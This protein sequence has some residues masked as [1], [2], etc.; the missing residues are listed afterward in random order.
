MGDSTYQFMTR[1]HLMLK[2]EMPQNNSGVVIIPSNEKG[3]GFLRTCYDQTILEKF[4]DKVEFLQIIDKIGKLMALEYSKKR[5]F[6]SR[7]TPFFQMMML[8]L[9][10]TLL[11]AFSIM[12]LYTPKVDQLWFDIL[13]YS[14]LTLS[15][16]IVIFIS[17]INFCGSKKKRTMTYNEMVRDRLT[18]FFN[19][20]NEKLRKR[21]LEWVM[22][23]NHYWIELRII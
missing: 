22:V 2:L 20:I 10:T 15:F 8:I 16:A 3:T 17:T 5:K 1:E 12:G 7:G 23:E 14:I 6:D 18:I 21:G 13:T 11:I 19:D 9:S 4:M